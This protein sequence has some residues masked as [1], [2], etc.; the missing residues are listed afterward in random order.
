MRTWPSESS[1][2]SRNQAPGYRGACSETCCSACLDVYNHLQS[3]ASSGCLRVPSRPLEREPG[4]AAIEQFLDGG[5]LG[6]G[7][8]EIVARGRLQGASAVLR[9]IW[10]SQMASHAEA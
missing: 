7:L 1:I 4:A 2:H 5:G 6:G 9:P 8:S 3:A 10:K